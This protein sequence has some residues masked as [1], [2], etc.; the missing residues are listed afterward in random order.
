MGGGVYVNAPVR[1]NNLI[2][3]E[4][5]APAV[6]F[7][8]NS[9]E[10]RLENC[11]IIKNNGYGVI[12]RGS[13][14][15]VIQNCII[16][17]N[18]SLGIEFDS[19]S[20]RLI[21]CTIVNNQADVHNTGGIKITNASSD[22]IDIFNTIVHENQGL[23]L[24]VNLSSNEY[25]V[26]V[27]TSL[28]QDGLEGVYLWDGN[29]GVLNWGEENMDSNPI[30]IDPHNNNYQLSDF[31]PAIGSGQSESAPITDIEGN[32][33]PNPAGTN[34]D[35]GAYE[36]FL[37]EAEP[38]IYGD[39]TM[40]GTVSSFDASKILKHVVG[41]DTLNYLQKFFGDVSQN[42][43]LSSLDASY[44]LQYVVGLIDDL[45]YI[46][47]NLLANGEFI[48]EDM[49]GSIGETISIPVRVTNDSNVHSFSGVLNYNNEVLLL[50]TIMAGNYYS[51]SILI[52]NKREE[53]YVSFA[54]SGFEPNEGFDE[55]ALVIFTI[56]DGFNG[57]TTVSISNLELNENNAMDS[58][59]LM[60]INSTMNIDKQMPSIYT[61]H[62]NFPNPFN[63]KTQINYDLPEDAL[64]KV[65][66]YDVM[67]RNVK[68]L[69]NESQS[70]GHHSI[71]WDGK[72]DMG[73]DISAGMYI[74]TI[75]AGEYRSTKKM[76]LIK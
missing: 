16:A 59:I 57:Y 74:Y 26:N 23:Q 64:V 76:V 60:T 54:S 44:I 13:A 10:A 53:G 11:F 75:L 7:A 35:I 69:M 52:S 55:I 9:G 51:N 22:Y 73:E 32:P 65:V 1:L 61:L 14:N 25:G 34:P 27:N 37:G 6:Y 19:N 42:N 30:F 58:T 31:S 8:Y 49:T 41:V 38:A 50:D 4:N 66:I 70:S 63:P 39:V 72:N 46:P 68:T 20:G 2:I 3:M 48:M 18:G 67:G 28:F 29:L 36:N 24:L 71:L 47:Y 15:P 56:L 17:D 45:P 21:N 40:N 62:Q 5:I 12:A 43:E 33:R